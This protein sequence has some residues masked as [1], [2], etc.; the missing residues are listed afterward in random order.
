M[1]PL[2]TP[3]LA[4]LLGQAC[5]TPSP[6]D[7]PPC[8]AARVPGCLPGYRP[9]YDRSGRLFY[10]CNNPYAQ[11][12]APL[13]SQAPPPLQP[14][15]QASVAPTAPPELAVTPPPSDSRGHVGLV[16]MPGVSAFP[17][18]HGFNGTKAEGQIA[19]EFRG[20]EGGARVR[21]TAEYTSFGKIGELS[22]KYDFLEGFFFRPWLA[23]GLGIASINPD[24][25]VR[26]S[27]SASAGVDL[28]ISRDFFLTGE[29]KG[30]LF[31]EGTQG[32]AHGLAISDRRQI[33]LLA[34]MGFYF[35]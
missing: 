17:N 26:A 6:Y 2:T 28:Y 9:Q 8:A 27:G 12:R 22:F 18:Y 4:A 14:A 29:L 35:F 10:V 15:S 31:T 11:P 20:S 5:P 25:A 7:P 33:S 32:A 13:Q 23:V 30:R 34:G 24:P 1:L 21:L 19:L 3:L 16:F